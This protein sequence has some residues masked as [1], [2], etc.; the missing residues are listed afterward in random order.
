MLQTLG[1]VD[2]HIG[3]RTPDSGYAVIRL[4]TPDKV[5][6]SIRERQFDYSHGINSI[7]DAEGR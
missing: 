5:V 6:E 3:K 1:G 2:E 7:M 4:N